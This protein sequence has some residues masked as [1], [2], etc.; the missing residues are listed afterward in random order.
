AKDKTPYKLHVGAVISDGGRKDMQIPGL[1]VQ[2]SVEEQWMGGGM[3]MPDKENLFKIRQ[4]IANEPEKWEKLISDKKF[5]ELF[6][7]IKGEKNKILSKDVKALNSDNPWLFNKQFYCM[8]EYKDEKIP[9]RKDLL[10]FILNH[11]VVASG[12][13]DFLKSAI[14]K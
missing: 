4:A 3:Y 13:N 9:L 5:V 1:Y 14:M 7:S 6:G 2:L 12:V 11:Q 10:S 8:A